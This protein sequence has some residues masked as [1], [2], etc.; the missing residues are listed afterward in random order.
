MTRYQLAKIVG[1]AGT[2]QTRKRLQ[3]V[4]YLLQVAGCPLGG[5]FS[6]HHYGPYS[7]EVARLTDE[8]VRAGLLE[9]RTAPNVAGQQYSY[10]LSE[11]AGRQVAEFEAGAQ[12]SALARRMAPFEG[13]A[14]ELL[15]ADLRDLEVAATIV[16]FR[17]QGHDWPVAVEKTCQF[18]GL[19]ADSPFVKGAEE[20]ARRIV[21]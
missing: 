3:K 5:E 17:E 21:A 15:G 14:R 20:L 16:F 11:A 13:R 19:T 12:G 18:K 2:L 9:E 8:T 1:W 7:Q 6:L 4:A 10:M